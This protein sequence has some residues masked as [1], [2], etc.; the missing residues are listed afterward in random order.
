MPF[1][2][3]V[4]HETQSV[5]VAIRG[6]LSGHD[7]LTDLA[8][9]TDSI[10]IEGLPVGWTAHRGMLQAAKFLYSQLV[11]LNLIEDAL[12]LNPGYDLVVTGH[13]LGAGAAV[14][15][16]LLLKTKYPQLRCYAFSPPGGLLSLAAARY[17][18][19]YCMTVIVG[20]DLVPRLSLGNI[21]TLK[22]QLTAELTAC[23]HPKVL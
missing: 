12:L 19:S 17:T 1:Y 16:S 4:D 14:L 2:V 11:Q 6:T 22:R 21:E 15:L 23:K 9:V 3:A 18:E 5:V 7:A 8:A 13:S 20:D 10:T